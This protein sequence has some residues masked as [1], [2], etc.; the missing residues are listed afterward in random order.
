LLNEIL[1]QSIE[2]NHHSKAEQSLNARQIH[3]PKK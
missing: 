1:A 3:S 2:E